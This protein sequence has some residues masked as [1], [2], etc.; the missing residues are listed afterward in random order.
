M[1]V[2][3]AIK[4]NNEVWIG[5]DSFLG[6]WYAISPP[7][8]MVKLNPLGNSMIAI[9]GTCTFRDIIEEM[10]KEDKKWTITDRT[11]A[12]KI[13]KELYLRLKEELEEGTVTNK[14]AE[15]ESSGFIICTKDNIYEIQGDT[16]CLVHEEMHAMGAGWKEAVSVLFAL[17][18]SD[19]SNSEV[20]ERAL[21]TA[22]KLNPLCSEPVFVRKV[23]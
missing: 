6:N 23:E 18:D 4:R 2:I 10:S 3:A 15:A 16:S 7:T 8:D 13:G 22:C 21:K 20:L 17:Y 12:R 14:E 19:F 11:S 5:A 9:T 1:T